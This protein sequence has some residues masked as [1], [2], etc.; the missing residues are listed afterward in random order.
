MKLG[1]FGIKN[2]SQEDINLNKTVQESIQAEKMYFS[3]SPIYSSLPP[4]CVG[5]GSLVNC[6]TKVLS[7][8]ITKFLPEL[9]VKIKDR[10]Q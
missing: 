10:K 4:Q 9:V 2:R 6:L 7:K 3:S 1:F 8:S 5:T